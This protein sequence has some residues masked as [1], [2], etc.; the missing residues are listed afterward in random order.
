MEIEYFIHPKNVDNCPFIKEVMDHEI[1]I[2]SDEMQSKKEDGQKMTIKQALDKKIIQTQWHAYWLAIEHKWFVGLG[3]APDNFRIRQHV[4]TEKSHYALDTWDLE[5]NFSFGWKELQGMANRTDFD[6]KE[7]MK[8]S[9]KDFSLFIQEDNNKVV[10][11]VVAEPSQ[12]V[13]R[14]FLVFISDAYCDDKERGN[15]VLKLDPKLAPTKVAV[16]PLVNKDGVGEKAKEVYSAIKTCF[17]SFYD[18]GGS[19]GRR[20]ARQDEVG[21]PYCVTIDYDTL[22]DNSVTIR[23]RDTTEQARIKIDDLNKTLK[24]LLNKEIMFKEV[25]K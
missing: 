22:K 13:D 5:Y 2:L 21:T 16:F 20:Y 11:Y 17:N 8:F 19:I 24:K 7:H 23:D 4:Q 3:A 15:I 12:G 25:K 1:I 14:A 18:K 10:P 6:L 9:K